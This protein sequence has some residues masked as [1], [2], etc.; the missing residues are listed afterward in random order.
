MLIE[1]YLHILNPNKKNRNA[2]RKFFNENPQLSHVWVERTSHPTHLE[3]I[4]EWALLK[5]ITQFSLWGG[6]GSFNRMVQAL[7]EKEA[8]SQSTLALVPV[9]T[10][11]DFSRNLEVPHWEKLHSILFSAESQIQK[12]DLGLVEANNQKR[13]FVNNAGFGREP[14]AVVGPRPNPLSDIG[15]FSEKKI[16]VECEGGASKE[17]E[18][19]RVFLGIIFNAP[20]FN[21]GLY[22]DKKI[23]P[24]DGALRAVMVPPQKRW[25]LIWRF[26]KGR[27]GTSLAQEGDRWFEGRLIRIESDQ[28]LYPQVDG[29]RAVKNGVHSLQFSILEQALNLLVPKGVS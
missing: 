22:F 21:K 18:T 26:L 29:E 28:P 27:L 16:E 1:S 5:K 15:S 20:Y 11:N 9:G 6:D 25:K 8:L 23:S 12:F 13:I 24:N 17:Y 3:T 10:G 19:M 2:V 4:V 7:Y 14:K